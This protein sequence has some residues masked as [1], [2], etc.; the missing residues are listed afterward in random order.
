MSTSIPPTPPTSPPPGTEPN[1]F[2]SDPPSPAPILQRNPQNGPSPV[3]GR[4]LVLCFDGTGN[5]FGEVGS[6]FAFSVFQ[7]LILLILQEVCEY[8]WVLD[9]THVSLEFKRRPVLPCSQKGQGRASGCVLSA[10]YRNVP[11]KD[12]AYAHHEHDI[13][14]G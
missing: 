14:F 7:C 3:A 11:E 5:K 10:G 12:M 13:R 2:L 8:T 1:V 9:S 6:R 4:V